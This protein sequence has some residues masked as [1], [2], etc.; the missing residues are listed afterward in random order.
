MEIIK[1]IVLVTLLIFFISCEKVIS[2]DLETAEPRLVIDASIDWIK[3]TSGN[4]QKIKLSTTTSY[5]SDEFPAVSGATI[6]ITN[7]AHTVFNFVEDQVKGEY[8][9]NNFK[10]MIG[11]TYTLKIILNGE[12]YTSTETL[13]ASPTIEN[14]IT[15]NN[16][17]GMAGDEVEITYYYQ[18]NGEE[19]NYYLNSI[20]TKHIVFPQY[21]V[22]NDENSQGNLIP[23]YYSNKDLKAGD[24][25]NIKLYGISKNY[26]TYF[27]KLLSASGN[28]DNPF[29]TI[30]NSVRGNIINQTHTNNFAYGYFRLSEVSIKDYTIQ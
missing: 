8:I 11:E 3:N 7:S 26:Y 17:G 24:L 9:C 29:P 16:A 20:M 27:K 15:Q 1:K 12:T 14:T 25:V 2:V 5:Y 4:I 22:E 19:E 10:P 13:I 21:Q 30:P 18:D 28:D 6:I 23:V